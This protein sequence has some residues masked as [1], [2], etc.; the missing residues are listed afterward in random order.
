MPLRGLHLKSHKGKR[1]ERLRRRLR[2]LKRALSFGRTERRNGC[3]F[4][5]YQPLSSIRLCHHLRA[6]VEELGESEGMEL[7]M[8]LMVRLVLTRQPLDRQLKVLPLNR[9]ALETE[10]EMSPTP[11]ALTLYPPLRSAL[12]ALTLDWLIPAKAPKPLTETVRLREP[13]M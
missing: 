5:M 12:T 11:L 1:R 9:M 8:P 7:A 13:K 2:R 10:A 4:L 6:G 3:L